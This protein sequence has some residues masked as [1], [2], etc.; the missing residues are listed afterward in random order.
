MLLNVLFKLTLYS[1][2]LLIYL[3]VFSYISCLFCVTLYIIV[4]ILRRTKYY[5]ELE[6]GL[7][8]LFVYL[9]VYCYLV[10]LMLW[11]ITSGNMTFNFF[12]V[13]VS[14]LLIWLST[15]S[16]ET[17]YFLLFILSSVA[18]FEINWKICMLCL[19]RILKWWFYSFKLRV[20]V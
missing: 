11:S 19:S 14:M 17:V 7:G 13:N 1:F 6:D 3:S 12:L 9:I 5:C 2:S 15:S 4:Q 18:I 16:E 20:R 10:S 8:A